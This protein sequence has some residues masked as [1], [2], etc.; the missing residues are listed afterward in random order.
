MK[1][2]VHHCLECGWGIHEAKKHYCWFKQAFAS[3]ECGLPFISLFDADIVISP[4]YIKFGEQMISCEVIDEVIDQWEGIAI[5][6]GPLVQ[7]SIILHWLEF[8]ILF[9][10]EEEPTHVGG[11]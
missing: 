8:S 11:V 7:V 1:D 4:S 10:N 5:W 9:S 2:V 6:Y 3:F